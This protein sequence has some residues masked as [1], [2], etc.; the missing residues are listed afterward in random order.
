MNSKL[1]FSIIGASVFVCV[2]I[3]IFT[4]CSMM[5]S[6]DIQEFQV[7]QSI[8]GSTEIRSEGGFYFKFMPKIWTYKKVNSVWL[9]FFSVL[10][11]FFRNI[12]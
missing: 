1:K 2:I 12:L 4:S 9:E 3:G 8:D 10:L 11:V 6:N 5:H 7:V